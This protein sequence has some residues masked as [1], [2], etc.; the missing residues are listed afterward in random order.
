MIVGR[1][2]E[3]RSDDQED[4]NG[5][6]KD[7]VDF[8]QVKYLESQEV[9]S[10]YQ[11][12][13]VNDSMQQNVADEAAA[14]LGNDRGVDEIMDQSLEHKRKFLDSVFDKMQVQG[15]PE[16]IATESHPL[17]EALPEESQRATRNSRTMRVQTVKVPR[18]HFLKA[19]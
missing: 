15:S 10:H 8:F 1:S 7:L 13:N 5:D 17:E 2:D 12:S 16:D 3:D 19:S 11:P 18:N 14:P 4:K 9:E 6:D